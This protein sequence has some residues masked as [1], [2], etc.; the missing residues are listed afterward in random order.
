MAQDPRFQAMKDIAIYIVLAN[1]KK[2]AREAATWLVADMNAQIE[3]TKR[4]VRPRAGGLGEIYNKGFVI[5][6]LGQIADH[7]LFLLSY[8]DTK[9]KGS[10]PIKIEP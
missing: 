4:P 3:D 8:E 9:R 6:N 1:S 7:I 10:R 5:G 2:L